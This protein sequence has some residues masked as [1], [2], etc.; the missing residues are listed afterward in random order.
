MTILFEHT[1][2]DCRR[3]VISTLKE[4]SGCDDVV[5]HTLDRDDG[6]AGV[7]V[8]RAALVAALAVT[9]A[10]DPVEVEDGK[11]AA[12]RLGITPKETP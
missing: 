12:A 5:I 4:R 10:P 1:D 11:R 7:F 6:W 9:A 2:H 3:L 8:P